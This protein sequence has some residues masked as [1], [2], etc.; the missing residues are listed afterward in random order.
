MIIQNYHISAKTGVYSMG[1]S[2]FLW[3]VGLK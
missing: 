1:L 2:S 3:V